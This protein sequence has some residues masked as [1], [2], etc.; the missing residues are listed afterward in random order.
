M[1]TAGDGLWCS[2]AN[3]G[4]ELCRSVH[5]PHRCRNIPVPGPGGVVCQV[6]VPPAC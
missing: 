4:L 5:K 2:V 6:S 3:V 1:V